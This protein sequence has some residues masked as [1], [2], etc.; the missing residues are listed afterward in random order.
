M[1]DR[2]PGRADN[3]PR[4]FCQCPSCGKKGFYRYGAQVRHSPVTGWG[5]TPPGQRCK[6][7]GYRKAMSLDQFKVKLDEANK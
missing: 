4:E 2:G 3:L 7:C 6:Y 5:G 1:A